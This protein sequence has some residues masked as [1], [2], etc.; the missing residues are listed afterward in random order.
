MFFLVWET[1]KPPEGIQPVEQPA[2]LIVKLLPFQ[3]EGV[4]WMVHQEL[5][6]PFQGGILA[7]EVCFV[8][9]PA[10]ERAECASFPW[11]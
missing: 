8:A 9:A 5:Y 7:D 11:T 4:A 2:K 3:L 6:S 1:I 10:G